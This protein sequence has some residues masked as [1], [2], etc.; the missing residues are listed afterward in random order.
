MR[1]QGVLGFQ[2][3]AERSST[4]VTAPAGLPLYLDLVHSS[5]LA[6]AIR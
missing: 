3:E 2:Y 1:P 4:G 6:A 5:D